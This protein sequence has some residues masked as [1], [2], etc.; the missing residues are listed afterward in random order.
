MFKRLILSIMLLSGA[1]SVQAMNNPRWKDK[2]ACKKIYNAAKK[3]HTQG[4]A[5]KVIKALWDAWKNSGK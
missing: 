4:I 5:A 3:K 2:E 1:A